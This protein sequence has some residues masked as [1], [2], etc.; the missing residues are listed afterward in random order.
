MLRRILRLS[1][2]VVAA[3]GA[4]VYLLVAPPSADLAAQEYRA[5]L[6]L[7]LWNNGWFAGHHTPGYS[8]LFPPLGGLLGVRLTGAIAAVTAAALFTPLARDHWPTPP[9]AGGAAALWFAAGT[10]A[11][12]LTG[13]LTFLLGVA[14]GLGAL[15]ALARE[16]R[17]A[18][19]VLAA[20]TTLASPVA[21]L[22]LALCVTAWALAEPARHRARA[23][24]W[25]A[26]IAA[27]ALVPIAISVLL[28]PEGGTHNLV[29]SSFWPA[30]ATSLAVA[31][32]LPARERALRVGAL[33]YALLLVAA[34]VIDSPLGGNATRLGALAIGPVVLGVLVGRR[35]PLL[36][37]ALAVAAAYWPLYPAVRDVV[38]ASGDPS[39]GTA[40]YAPLLD[41]LRAR[42]GSFRV[43][44]PYTENHWEARRVAPEFPL[45][46]GWE[47][48]L[49]RL[50][51]ALFYDG[52]LDAGAYRAW[53]DRHAVAYVAV[54]DVALDG[55]GRDEARL[56]AAGLPYLR[57]A[58]HDEHWRV[59]AVARP[60]A[61]AQA[62]TGVRALARLSPTGVR[63][64]ATGPGPVLL[65]VRFTR[66]WRVTG[67]RGCVAEAPGGMTRVTFAAPGTISL[68]ARLPGAACR[69]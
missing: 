34:F 52:S 28:F 15:L 38:R 58:W 53:L 12:L 10:T 63:I 69:R 46:R 23:W 32:L 3:L 56:V 37:A 33:L 20:A 18:A 44:I 13:R 2:W 59:F 41:F 55:A 30:L 35:S 8:V 22:F 11:V 66:W 4:A 16:H 64:R 27:A 57:E 43:E 21:G 7:T 62:G 51:G 26:A 68:Q 48:Q 49:D 50:Y 45:A 54:P 67:G 42:P 24:R 17:A 47:R 5:E 31:A 9:R 39:V 19:A 36:I 25:G 60:A 6:G 29:G 40:Y 1:P 61:L 65:R 14:I